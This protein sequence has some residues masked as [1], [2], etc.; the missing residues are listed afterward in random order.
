MLRFRLRSAI[1]VP[2]TF[3]DVG[4]DDEMGDMDALWAKLA[5]QDLSQGALPE[6]ADRKVQVPGSSV[7]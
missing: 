2:T 6:L 1:L 7:Q 5:S 4:I 3:V